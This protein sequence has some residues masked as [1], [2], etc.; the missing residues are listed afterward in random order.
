MVPEDSIKRTGLIL[1]TQIVPEISKQTNGLISST[2]PE[3]NLLVS[4]EILKLCL[5]I[6]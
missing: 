1:I 5:M 6:R 3:H 4:F 2:G